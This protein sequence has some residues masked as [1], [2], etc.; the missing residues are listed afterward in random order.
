MQVNRCMNCMME[1][2]QQAIC[3]HCGYDES[4]ENVLPYALRPNSI[5]HGKYLV[6][7]V[8]GQGGFGITYVGFD[9]S[10]ES[11]VAI[12]EY[13]PINQLTRNHMLTN[14]VSWNTNF[15]QYQPAGC[16]SFLREARK[17]AKISSVPSVVRVRETFNENKTAYIVMDFAEGITLRSWLKENG[18]L[19]ILEAVEM[20]LPLIRSIDRIHQF[21]LIHRDIS[22][23]NIMVQPDGS[24][25]LLDF[26]AAK[27]MMA[28][29]GFKSELVVK[30]G[31]SP[32]EQYLD[33]GN[34]GPWT[35]VYSI[36]ATL[37]YCVTGIV[38]SRAVDR[39]DQDKLDFSCLE[40]PA[41]VTECLRHGLAVQHSLRIQEA[42]VLADRLQKAIT[43]SENWHNLPPRPVRYEPAKQNKNRWIVAAAVSGTIMICLLVM[44]V[45]LTIGRLRIQTTDVS[46]SE[47][48]S[49]D[50]EQS[51]ERFATGGTDFSGL[52]FFG[53]T[54]ED[55]LQVEA[56]GMPGS[57][58]INNG[59]YNTVPGA[60]EYF[61]DTLG[62][63]RMCT[64]ENGTVYLNDY[65][66][67]DQNVCYLLV[68]SSQ[69]YYLRM[70]EDSESIIQAD[71]DGSNQ[72]VLLTEAC[73][74]T[75]QYVKLS[76]QSEWLY[77]ILLASPDDFAGH[78][79]RMNLATGETE[80]LTD[81]MV[82]WSDFSGDMMYYTTWDSSACAYDWKRSDLEM[83]Q[84]ELLVENSGLFKGMLGEDWCMMYDINQRGYRFFDLD[85]NS[86]AHP[87]T[88]LV[89]KYSDSSLSMLYVDG[90]LYYIDTDQHSVRRVYKD[91]TGNSCILKNY[92]IN[93]MSYSDGWLCL[94]GYDI[95]NTVE[96]TYMI[97]SD[98]EKFIELE[99]DNLTIDD[100]S[101]IEFADDS[102]EEIYTVFYSLVHGAEFD[103]DWNAEL[104]D[105]QGKSWFPVI[106]E[107]VQTLED[108][109]AYWEQ[110]GLFS[111]D[112][113]MPNFEYFREF[114]GRLYS[115]NEGTGGDISLEE[116]K[117]TGIVWREGVYALME[118]EE[119]RRD[120]TGDGD[121]YY[122][123]PIYMQ[124]K[125][126]NGLWKCCGV[127]MAGW[128]YGNCG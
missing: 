32:L 38:P 109:K 69:L 125:Y 80:Q 75:L 13:F 10:L 12:K 18:R 120:L 79:F 2:E 90:W 64:Y 7:R 60:Y 93:S 46:S 45:V 61:V 92:D 29:D 128:E 17:M 98:G 95:N 55:R 111:S 31:F 26:G 89:N 11:K 58:V 16:E 105:E 30:N 117:I 53:E 52:D 63:L 6:G 3:P 25:C 97:K 9:L 57:N 4:K 103:V 68:G 47:F 77:F 107:S 85:G 99:T 121:S 48:R 51:E 86:I 65:Q 110:S 82:C 78:N 15:L 24:L 23:D 14:E 96:H 126:E 76:D 34:I 113:E 88:E 36:C 119:T 35:D 115:G 122:N 66:I 5:L 27:D 100:Q 84:S 50:W 91:G 59:W 70:N 28:T 42:S 71:F 108:L 72:T 62:N 22:P 39:M 124:F 106:D 73:F 116:M 1:K 114:N 54:D 44:S 118:G 67:I 81:E 40:C 43:A 83:K 123:K 20:L 49:L 102:V 112:F 21:G 33:H 87:L 41:E 19:S 56:L 104:V 37:Y 8:L 94:S 127:R 101:L 74:H